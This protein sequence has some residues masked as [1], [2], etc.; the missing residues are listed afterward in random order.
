MM[1]QIYQQATHALQMAA[2]AQVPHYRVDGTDLKTSFTGVSMVAFMCA[3]PLHIPSAVGVLRGA[4]APPS[5]G[6]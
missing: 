2:Q 4:R 5:P 3:V 1:A 6:R